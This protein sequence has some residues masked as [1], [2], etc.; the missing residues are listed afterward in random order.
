MME[1][2]TYKTAW[3]MCHR[4]RYAMTQEPMTGLLV[5]TVEADETYIGGKERNKHASKRLNVGSGT[6]GKPPIFALIERD[7]QLR[8]HNVASVTG[9]NLKSIIRQQVLLEARIMMDEHGA[10]RGLDQGFAGHETVAHSRGEYVRGESHTNTIEGVF[11]LFKRQIVGAH[12]HVSPEHLDR[13]WDEF[14]WK[15][16]RRKSTVG[17]KME[18]ALKATEG[19]RLMYKEPMVRFSVNQPSSPEYGTI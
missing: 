12:H 15:Y 16:N 14:E 9:E 11:S 4:I 19:K 8:G 2:I 17:E 13:Y 5:G 3:F 18:M 1:P 10:Y 7:G 6:G